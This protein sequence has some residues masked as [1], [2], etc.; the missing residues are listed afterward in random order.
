MQRK[1]QRARQCS[2][3]PEQRE[4]SQQEDREHHREAGREFVDAEQVIADRNKPIRERRFLQKTH[5]VH[6]K[7]DVIPGYEHFACGF[8]VAA[9]DVVEQGGGKH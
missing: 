6:V 2:P 5:A 4:N 3:C 8:G 7:R 1:Y 9:V